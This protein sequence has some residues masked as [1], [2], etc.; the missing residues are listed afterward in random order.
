MGIV[1]ERWVFTASPAEDY[2]GGSDYSCTVNQS[3]TDFS[4][5]FVVRD[6]NSSIT[7]VSAT[8]KGLLPDSTEVSLGSLSVVHTT[9]HPYEYNNSGV[10]I[11]TVPYNVAFSSQ[12][13]T[14]K[15]LILLTTSS[16]SNAESLRF[17]I[18][19]N[20]VS[21]I[22]ERQIDLDFC[23]EKPPIR[24]HLSQNNTNF[25]LI[26]NLFISKGSWTSDTNIVFLRARRPDGSELNFTVPY[27]PSKLTIDGTSSYL[28][29]EITKVPG[30]YLAS[31]SF[32]QRTYI[33]S[34][35]QYRYLEVNTTQRIAFIIEP[36]QT[37]GGN[38]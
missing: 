30:E 14:A 28:G 38:S 24:I 20:P 4:F 10:W 13:G 33:E 1:H 32:C 12:I 3:Q 15:Y 27:S 2:N 8:L 36:M 16:Q 11:I 23:P 31:F 19:V 22:K 34:L 7:Y 25:K 35:H 37:E 5:R 21:N 26:F 9:E 17:N 6:N 18:T 29:A